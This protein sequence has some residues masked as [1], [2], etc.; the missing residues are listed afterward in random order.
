MIF[1]N[2]KNSLK[3]SKSCKNS[4]IMKYCYCLKNR[5]VLN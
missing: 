5:F 4:N 1:L 2:A 3:Y